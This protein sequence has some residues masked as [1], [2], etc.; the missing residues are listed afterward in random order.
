MPPGHG[1]HKIDSTVTHLLRNPN[2]DPDRMPLT[3]AKGQIPQKD[4]IHNSS[5]SSLCVGMSYLCECAKLSQVNPSLALFLSSSQPLMGFGLSEMNWKGGYRGI[6]LWGK[7]WVS[8]EW[9]TGELLVYLFIMVDASGSNVVD[10][11]NNLDAGNPLYVQNSDNSN[12]A[13]I[14]FKLI[15]TENY[16]IW[17]GAMKLALQ[18]R[19]KYGFVDGSCLKKSYATSDVLYAQWDRCNTMI[20]TWIMNVVSQDVYMGLI[21]SENAADV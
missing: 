18:A 10:C 2:T 14:P 16:R 3:K 9:C 19:N 5:F 6:G 8:C 4:K 1:R 17:S 7:V 20:M 15:G 21:Y 12:S 13:L 11:I